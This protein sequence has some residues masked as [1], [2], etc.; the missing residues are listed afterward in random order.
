M[1][2]YCSLIIMKRT[3]YLVSFNSRIVS[4]LEKVFRCGIGLVSNAGGC[5]CV[6][7]CREHCGGGALL[8]VREVVVAALFTR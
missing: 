5:G 6:R 4:L 2:C 8:V 7:V 1:L 3:A